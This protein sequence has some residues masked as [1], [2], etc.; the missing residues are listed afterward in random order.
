MQ[1]TFAGFIAARKRFTGSDAGRGKRAKGRGQRQRQRQ[2]Q[3]LF[4]FLCLM[5]VA[6]SDVVGWLFAT[7]TCH[8]V[9]P[10]PSPLLGVVERRGK[11]REVGSAS[12]CYVQSHSRLMLCHKIARLNP[13]YGDKKCLSSPSLSLP[14]RFS[15]FSLCCD[16]FFCIF[17]AFSFAGFVWLT[18]RGEGKSE[19]GEDEAEIGAAHKLRLSGAAAY[20]ANGP[21]RCPGA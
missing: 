19:E 15:A 18:G 8:K 16:F 17:F 4:L 12:L 21:V 2:R 9:C 1:R 20:A 11:E 10:F 3:L 13:R 5:L 14:S 6:I 7:P